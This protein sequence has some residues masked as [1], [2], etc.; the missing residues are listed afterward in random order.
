MGYIKD[1]DMFI[2]TIENK[3]YQEKL[4]KTIN[5]IKQTFP[6]LS[7]E[8]KWNQPMFIHKGTFIL[9]FSVSKNHFSVAPEQKAMEIFSD[10][11]D[12]A[13]YSQTKMLFRIK[14]SQGV[15]Y[16][17][18]KEIIQFNIEDKRGYDKFWRS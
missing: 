5:W 7:L 13:G 15:N 14:Y 16:V 2:E 18:L 4:L 12:D 1:L 8:I 3:E 11:I 10:K 6:Q 17:L 9:A